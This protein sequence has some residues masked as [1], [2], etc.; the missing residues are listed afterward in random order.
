MA[1]RWTAAAMM[2][3]KRGFPIRQIVENAGCEGSIIVGRISEHKSSTYCYNAQ[4]EEYV[5]AISSGIVD[6]AKVVRTALQ[7]AASVAGLLITTEAMI[8]DASNDK[9]AMPMGGMG[10]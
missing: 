10:Y 4:T 1:L 9:P 5:D 8:A 2:E 3:A 7:N 6:P